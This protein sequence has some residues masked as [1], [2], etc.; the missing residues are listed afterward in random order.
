MGVGGSLKSRSDGL[1][2]L[3]MRNVGVKGRHVRCSKEDCCVDVDVFQVIDH[4]IC[5]TDV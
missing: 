5:V 4:V 2:S 3:V 1:N